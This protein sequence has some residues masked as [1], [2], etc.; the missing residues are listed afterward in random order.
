MT[1]PTPKTDPRPKKPRVSAELRRERKY[2]AEVTAKCVSFACA[3]SL[4]F[5]QRNPCYPEYQICRLTSPGVRLVVY[6]HRSGNGSRH[7]RVRNDNSKDLVAAAL[8]VKKLGLAVKN[9]SL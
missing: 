1:D 2:W 4:D 9:G 3:E 7:A 8:L 6:P 5:E